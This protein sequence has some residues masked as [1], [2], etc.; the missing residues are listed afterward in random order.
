MEQF[1]VDIYNRLHFQLPQLC[2][3]EMV[4]GF[5]AQRNMLFYPQN[6]QIGDAQG[7]EMKLIEMRGFR[8]VGG[9]KES[10]EATIGRLQIHAVIF[11]SLQLSDAYIG[12]LFLTLSTL[13]A[14]KHTQNQAGV[15]LHLLE[16]AGSKLRATYGRAFTEQLRIL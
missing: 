1:L 8:L 15:I 11:F 13:L 6:A 7:N 14:L 5:F 10:I 2:L 3:K 9:K 4:L 16:V 12:R